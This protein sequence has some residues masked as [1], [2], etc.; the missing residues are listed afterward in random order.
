MLRHECI[1]L[2][3]GIE[4]AF[5]DVGYNLR[6]GDQIGES[7]EVFITDSASEIEHPQAIRIAADLIRRRDRISIID[8]IAS[9]CP[10][11]TT[12]SWDHQTGERTSP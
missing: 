5:E 9:H 4:P 2:V 7:V 6:V 3:R 12:W 11:M 10:F 8:R 1:E